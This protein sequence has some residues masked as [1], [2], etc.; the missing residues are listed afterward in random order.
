MSGCSNCKDCAHLILD[1]NVVKKETIFSQTVCVFCWMPLKSSSTFQAA[2][3]MPLVSDC[4][5]IFHG[6]CLERRE[7][8]YAQTP[9]RCP[10]D[11]LIIAKTKTLHVKKKEVGTVKVMDSQKDVGKREELL[12]L[13]GEASEI[14]KKF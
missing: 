9:I 10:M 6:L 11:G 1:S 12:T 5:H 4:G 3:T 2:Q 8:L 7:R 14:A 13:L